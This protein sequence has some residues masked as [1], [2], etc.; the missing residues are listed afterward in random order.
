MKLNKL[1]VGIGLVLSLA[2]TSQLYAKSSAA[3]LKKAAS[4]IAAAK[5]A[6]AGANKVG[7]E[8]RDSGNMIKKLNKQ[9]QKVMR[10]KL[11]H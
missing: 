8:W 4:A 10:I 3:D 1:V 7:F 11:S 5:S 9:P 6:V 2:V